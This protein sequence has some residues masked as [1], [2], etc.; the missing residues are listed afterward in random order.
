MLALLR[1]DKF[2]LAAAV[3]L[4]V[5]VLAALVGP[6]LLGGIGIDMDLMARNAPPFEPDRGFWHILGSDALGR[7]ILA[8]IIIAARPT[9]LIAA[10][11]VL[12]SMV[13]GV[14][15]GL[16][17]GYKGGIV[18]D[19]IMRLTD[20]VMSFPSLLLALVVL[21][22][23]GPAIT[24]VI[25][26][27]AITRVPVYLRTTRAEVLEIRSRMFVVAAE[28]TGASV[29]RTVSRHI[30]PMVVPT[31]ATLMTIEF[32]FVMLAEASLSF[33]GLGVQAPDFTWGVMVAEGRSYL[34]TAWWLSFWPGVFIALVTMSLN[35]LSNWLRIA[36]DPVQR[37]RL[38]RE[39][40]SDE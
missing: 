20:I 40:A 2:A 17:A 5:V 9:L 38:E 35:L 1:R 18:G 39:V 16:I 33:L 29:F 12:L 24:N 6:P 31:I 37:W 25:I 32:A 8:R 3:F 26:V 15:L 13:V 4:V 28:V 19:V 11:A 36:T 23:F 34:A 21:Y 10:A 27:L 30:L 22:I 14:L 7:P